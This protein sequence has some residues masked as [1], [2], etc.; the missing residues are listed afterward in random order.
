[1]N[2][3]DLTKLQDEYKN[4]KPFPHLVINNLVSDLDELKQACSTLELIE[5]DSDLYNFLRTDD[6]VVSKN[7]DI[8]SFLTDMKER[9]ILMVADIVDTPLDNT[10]LSIDYFEYRKGHY[11]LCHDDEVDDRIVA[12]VFYLNDIKKKDGGELVIY[13][14]ISD[15]NTQDQDIE[16]KQAKTILPKANSLLIFKLKQGQ[17]FHEVKEVL[18]GTRKTITGWFYRK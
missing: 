5:C 17:S 11:L 15:N 3:D 1:M 2:S 13:E 12:F 18:A 4:N 14:N 8:Q 16:L 7:P 10:K 6:F 9:I